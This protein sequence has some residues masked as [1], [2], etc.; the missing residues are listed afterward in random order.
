M[1]QILTKNPG[2]YIYIK[3]NTEIIPFLLQVVI[4]F[5]TKPQ[6]HAFDNIMAEQKFCCYQISF[7]DSV[8]AIQLRN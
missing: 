2:V 6:V 8:P 4:G 7:I 3:A 5:K 1:L